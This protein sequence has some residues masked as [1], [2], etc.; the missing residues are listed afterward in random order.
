MSTARFLG[1]L[2]EASIEL[3]AEGDKLIVNAPKGAVTAEL[4]DEIRRRKPDLLVFLR[5]GAEAASQSSGARI[6]RARRLSVTA[7]Y[8]EAPASF[9]QRRLFY[10]DQLE[11]GLAVYNVPVAF[12]LA[13]EVDKDALSRALDRIVERHGALRTTLSLATDGVRQRIA[14]TARCPFEVVNLADEPAP[15]ARE[16][17]LQ[18]LL[19][20]NAR[21]SFDLGVGP[22]FRAVLV[23]LSS[24]ESVLLVLSHHVITDGWSQDVFQTELSLLY[25]AEKNGGEA[26]LPELPIAYADYASWQSETQSDSGRQK[27]IDYWR[28]ALKKPLPILELPTAHARPKMAPTAGET[29]SLLLPADL[30][31]PLTAIGRRDGATLFMV[32][33]AGYATLLSRISAQEDIVIGTPIANRAH[34]ET[35]DLI[36]Y[37]ANTLALRVDLSG[38][39]SFREL[40]RRV[41]EVCLG[42]YENQDIP[43][44]ELVEQLS[45]DRDLSRSPIFQTIFAFEDAMPSARAFDAVATPSLTVTR[46][47]TIHAKVART[48]LSAWVSASEGGLLVTFEYPTALFDAAAV[49]RLLDHFRVLLRAIADGADQPIDSLPLLSA[50]ERERILHRFNDTAVALPEVAGAHQLVERQVDQAPERTAVVFG[51]E[52]LSYRDLDMR[53]NRL[54][55]HL[56]ALG[57]GPDARIGVFLERSTSIVV[58]LLAVL[59][60]GASYVPLDPAYPKERVAMMIDDSGLR[61]VLTTSSLEHELPEGTPVVA[62]DRDADAIALR[63]ADRLAVFSEMAPSERAAYVI[64]TSGST[65]RPKGVVVPHRALINFLCSMAK[66]PGLT[67]GDT[68]VAVTTLSFDIAGLEMFLPLSV[69]AKLVIAGENETAEGAELSRLLAESQATVMQATPTTWRM[70]LAAGWA[71]GP[72]FKVLCG[73]EAFP[74]ELAAELCARAGDVWN[75]YGPTETTIWSTCI[76]LS[77]NDAITIGRPID[78]TSVYVLD[79]LGQP[80]PVGVPG[81]LTIGGLGVSLGYLARPELTDSRFVPDPFCNQTGARMYKTGDLASFRADGQLVY[82]RRLDHQ[83]KV[84]GH[85]IEP[86]EIEAV[87][88]ESEAVA[89]NVVIVREDRPGDVRLVAYITPRRGRQVTASDLRK[90]LRSRLPEYMIPQHFVELT[91]LPLTPAG[92]IARS[93]LP[94]PAGALPAADARQPTSAN[95]L[96]LADIWK[97]ALAADAVFASDNFFD[98]GGHSLLSMIVMARIQAETGVRVSPRDLLTGTLEQIAAKLPPK[99]EG[100]PPARVDPS[101]PS[102][103]K[104]PPSSS[105]PSLVGGFMSRIKGKIF[106]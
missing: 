78:N 45:V 47:E 1:R 67:S 62:L 25:D 15:D 34:S 65:G 46:R 16:S 6:P 56:Q 74:A 52:S 54:A 95:E 32:L 11:P 4:G 50:G 3:R 30:V 85:R 36:G 106:S 39:P 29:E 13:G 18:A 59:K 43:F 40:L 64:Y 103:A 51:S 60:L 100:R 58:A 105:K 93:E 94:P 22:L 35:L 48:D 26:A 55:H 79:A 82:H 61:F 17:R 69:G 12:Y 99:A 33:L 73:G 23:K 19:D 84:R 71:G 53:A 66:A 10:L 98:I 102:S 104:G 31:E 97:A 27:R 14:T 21:A 9:G 8:E 41:R 38:R 72:H 86:G 44:E 24:A 91:E 20:A 70:L 68:L 63:S 89:A 7:E 2:R 75:M 96:M 90:H 28:E 37:F 5:M 80:T 101:P 49:T 77:P 57:V 42:A 76:R 81:E 92:K 83:V 87:L 88:A